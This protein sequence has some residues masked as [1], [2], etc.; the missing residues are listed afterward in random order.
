MGQSHQST[1]NDQLGIY[2]VNA[3]GRWDL[4]DSR[5]KA[6][7]YAY[8]AALQGNNPISIVEVGTSERLDAYA[9][10]QGWMEL[11]LNLP[12]R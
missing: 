2:L 4:R 11:G 9:I 12:A 8:K 1:F 5:A 7:L 6:L 10:R 3:G